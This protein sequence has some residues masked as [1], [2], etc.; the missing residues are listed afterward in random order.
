MEGLVLRVFCLFLFLFFIILGVTIMGQHFTGWD[1][2][3]GVENNILWLY[4]R[5]SIESPEEFCLFVCLLLK[6]LKLWNILKPAVIICILY[7]FI[8][9]PVRTSKRNHSFCRIWKW[10]D[11]SLSDSSGLSQAV[12]VIAL[13]QGHSCQSALQF[14]C[15]IVPCSKDF[16]NSSS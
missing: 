3:Y 10:N 8:W 14:L 2:F 13:S 16:V 5:S 9:W 12:Y 7:L 6:Q 15:C 4:L 1:A 11:Y